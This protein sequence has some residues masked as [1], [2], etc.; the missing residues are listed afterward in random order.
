[1]MNRGNPYPLYIHGGLAQEA[2]GRQAVKEPD[3]YTA[4]ETE[5]FDFEGFTRNRIWRHC[6]LSF[7]MRSQQFCL[8]IL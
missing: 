8:G 7:R 2:L 5:R 3:E 6:F 4:L 1:M